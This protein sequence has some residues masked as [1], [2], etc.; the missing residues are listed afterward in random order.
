M[1]SCACFVIYLFI[2]LFWSGNECGQEEEADYLNEERDRCT[3]DHYITNS[4]RSLRV[5][6]CVRACGRTCTREALATRRQLT[7]RDAAGFHA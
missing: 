6:V 2:Y 3:V 4:C 5:C 1:P 7:V